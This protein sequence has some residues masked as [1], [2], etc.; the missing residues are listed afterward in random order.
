MR[1]L[2]R[3]AFGT[4]AVIT[5]AA[6]GGDSTGP[7]GGGGGGGAG[8]TAK[9]N[10]TSWS[11]TQVQVSAGAAGG[12]PGTIVITGVKVAGQ[13]TTSISVILGFISGPGTYRLGVN[14]ASTPGGTGLLLET[15][16][17]ATSEARTTP[18]T[19]AGG[20]VVITSLTSTRIKG[21]FD[22][23]AV[24]ILGSTFT[25]NKSITNGTFDVELPANFTS[26]PAANHGSTVQADLGGTPF[27][28]ATVVGIGSMGSYAFGGNT[29]E[30]DL[31]FVTQTPVNATGDYALGTGIRLTV[32]NKE[33]ND[34]WGGA[35]AA[36]GTVT[37]TSVANGR[38]VGTF[39]GTLQPN[40][41]APGTLVVANGSFDVRIDATP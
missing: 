2:L 21:T 9:I 19:G 4:A 18:F 29:E 32:Q 35:A 25:G 3:F 27:F 41:Q 26:V 10:A 5:A 6:C 23:V 37:I 1:H 28:G 12:V 8:M 15:A 7:G 14:Q 30:F 24:P 31:S 17:P 34:V 11:A 38:L 20:T 36:T 33:T 40:G 16:P 13:S 22:F 39:S